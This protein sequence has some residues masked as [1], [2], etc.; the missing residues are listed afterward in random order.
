MTKCTLTDTGVEQSTQSGRMYIHSMCTWA[1]L[2]VVSHAEPQTRT[3]KFKKAEIT[4]SIF[5]DHKHYE[6]RN[7]L[8]EKLQKH[9][10]HTHILTRG[11]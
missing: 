6:T 7:Q 5:S 9:N 4:V 3:G 8:Q 2:Q 1:S 11:G 10:K